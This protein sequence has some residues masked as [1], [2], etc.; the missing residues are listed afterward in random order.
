MLYVHC[1]WPRTGTSSL[2]A[3]LVEHG[4]L[5]ARGEL[6][7]PQRWRVPHLPAHN[8]LYDLLDASLRSGEDV[9]DELIQFLRANRVRDVLLSAEGLTNWLPAEDR[10]EALLRFLAAA[11]EVT[12]TRCLW[13]LRRV[14]EV[15]SSLYLLG[16]RFGLNMPPPEQ[17]V[18]GWDHPNNPFDASRSEDLFA[19][20]RMVEEALGGDV[21]YFAY[22]PGGAHLGELLDSLRLPIEVR[23]A[24]DETLDRGPRRNVSLSHKQAAAL[25]NV[26]ALSA[27]AGVEI[28][29]VA[30]RNAFFKGELS[31]DDD[32]P[33]DLIEAGERQALHERA[34][35]AARAQGFSPYGE[36]FGDAKFDPYSPVSL[37]AAVLSDADLDRLLGQQGLAVGA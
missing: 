25:L 9:F 20:M 13:T 28:D 37:E 30:L 22:D 8:G 19:G 33:C 11:R 14:D 18:A 4:E 3:A 32:R 2:Q 31:F 17:Y 5:L 7:Y 36:L 24:I 23:T 29:G 12:P 21:L 34:L 10:R 6:S 16:M 26:D 1:G 15:L 27:R 35:A